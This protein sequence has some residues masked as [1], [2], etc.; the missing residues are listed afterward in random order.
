MTMSVVY[1]IGNIT[2]RFI[3]NIFYYIFITY[4]FPGWIFCS[5]NGLEKVVS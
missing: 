1:P 5:Y 3:D 4:L 2:D